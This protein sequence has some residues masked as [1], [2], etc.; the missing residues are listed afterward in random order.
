MFVANEGKFRIY[1]NDS[2]ILYFLPELLIPA[3]F[4]NF[5]SYFVKGTKNALIYQFFSANLFQLLNVF[6]KPVQLV[7]TD[8]FKN[9]RGIGVP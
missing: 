3:T 7:A 5:L 2:L 9:Q 6:C 4:G 8:D 1:L